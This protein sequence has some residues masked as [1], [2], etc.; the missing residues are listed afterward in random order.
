M[1][2]SGDEPA[3]VIWS[4]GDDQVDPPKRSRHRR[5]RSQIV[6]GVAAVLVV[7]FAVV[8]VASRVGKTSTAG[9]LVTAPSGAV[10]DF[11]VNGDCQKMD[12][13]GVVVKGVNLTGMKLNGSILD[14]ADFTG[15]TFTNTDLTD[16]TFSGA[17]LDGVKSG[18][19]VGQKSLKTSCDNRVNYGDPGC[20]LWLDDVQ[21]NYPIYCSPEGDF[22]L[23]MSIPDGLN[24]RDGRKEWLPVQWQLVDGFL[25]GPRANLSGASLGNSDLSYLNLSSANL[26]NAALQNATLKGSAVDYADLEGAALRGGWER[27]VGSFNGVIVSY[28]SQLR[29]EDC[30]HSSAVAVTSADWGGPYH[31]HGAWDVLSFV[32]EF[33]QFPGC[34]FDLPNHG[35]RTAPTNTCTTQSITWSSSL[36]FDTAAPKTDPKQVAPSIGDPAGSRFPD[37]TGPWKYSTYTGHLFNCPFPAAVPTT[38]ATVPPKT[39][40]TTLPKT[41]TTL[42]AN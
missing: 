21:F 7:I 3:E 25:V 40:T 36:G 30:G 42:P 27:D 11:K 41:A 17:M 22:V 32:S 12:L 24:H 26:T 15:S 33:K 34:I 16:A 18:G 4:R 5:R 6:A 31:E 37:D 20:Q 35:P 10:C 8:G 2:F 23:C 19:V 13:H 39:T 1:D 9:T 38:A 28:G 14:G 29:V